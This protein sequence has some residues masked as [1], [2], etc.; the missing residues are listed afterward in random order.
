MVEIFFTFQV[1][2]NYTS[3]TYHPSEASY[4]TQKQTFKEKI[5]RL[6]IDGNGDVK[7]MLG[8]ADMS[9]GGSF[10]YLTDKLVDNQKHITHSHLTISNLG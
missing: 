10:R 4:W 9:L 8:F 5:D 7:I 2:K 1:V 3:I 6:N